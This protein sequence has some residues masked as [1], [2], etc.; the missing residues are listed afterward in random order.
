MMDQISSRSSIPLSVQYNKNTGYA[1][2]INHATMGP[3]LYLGF[4]PTYIARS[5][6]IQ[7]YRANGQDF[8]FRNCDANPNSYL[9]LFV[10]P[11]HNDPNGYYKRCCYTKLM[12]DWINVGKRTSEF[13]PC[14]YFFQFEMHMGGCGGYAV[15]GFNTLTDV[16]GAALGFQFGKYRLICYQ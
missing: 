14:N 13:L 12:R 7:G 3:Y 6:S 8:T 5:H 2:P 16:I 4:L 15:N 11:K 1:T 10:N 9:A